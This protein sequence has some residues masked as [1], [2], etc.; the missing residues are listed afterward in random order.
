MG[1]CEKGAMRVGITSIPSLGMTRL[2][3]TPVTGIVR[4]EVEDV[5]T[6]GIDGPTIRLTSGAEG[7]QFAPYPR[8]EKETNPE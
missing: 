4:A 8:K 6:A 2:R 5:D 7:H 3:I 1:A